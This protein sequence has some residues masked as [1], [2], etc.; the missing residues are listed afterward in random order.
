MQDSTAFS[1]GEFMAA[2]SG[3]ERFSPGAVVPRSGIYRVIHLGHRPP[4]ENSFVRGERFPACQI[5]GDT[6]RFELVQGENEQPS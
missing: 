6:V 3:I 5:C 2:G 1:A 4:H